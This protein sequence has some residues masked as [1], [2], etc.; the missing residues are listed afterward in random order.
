VKRRLKE[1]VSL[2]ACEHLTYVP[3]IIF[4]IK[5]WLRFLL[6]YVGFED[7]GNVYSFRNRT[8]IKT[9]DRL[10]A[11]TVAVVF[12]KKEY[13]KVSDNSV[14]IDIGANI[15]VYSL[16]AA[17]TSRS[18]TVYAYEPMPSSYALLLENIKLNRFEGR[19]KPFKLGVSSKK[20]RARLFLSTHSPF[21]S[22]C[23]SKETGRH[24]GIE[25]TSLE[26]IFVKNGIEHCDILKMDC[27]G[28]EYEILYS[29]PVKCLDRISEIRLEYHN[30]NRKRDENI[31]SLTRFLTAKGFNATVLKEDSEYSG[32]A[33]FGR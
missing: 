5:N 30:L 23:Q 28:A 6:N 14:I 3:V 7:S 11:V 27:E 33:W 8:K 17:S 25:C 10:D 13:G 9:A 12:V 19:I 20:G 4:K 24:I 29:T 2:E 18:T 32:H 31:K 21:H 15:G 16:Y 1:F 22:I 26:D